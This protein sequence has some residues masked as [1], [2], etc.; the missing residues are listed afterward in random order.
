MSSSSARPWIWA[1]FSSSARSDGLM[2]HHWVRAKVEYPDYP[3]ARFDVHLDPVEYPPP[4]GTSTTD[5]TTTS[6]LRNAQSQLQSSLT[7]PR[8][9]DTSSSSSS[10]E[11]KRLFYKTHLQ[12]PNWTQTETDT[13]LHLCHIH[14]LRWPIIHDKWQSHVSHSYSS[15]NSNNSNH[16]HN[17][18]T[19]P[20]LQHRYYTIGQI[21]NRHLVQQ[22]AANEAATLARN[23]LTTTTSRVGNTSTSTTP[24][25]GGG[26]GGSSSSSGGGGGGVDGRSLA[27][28][29]TISSSSPLGSKAVST[30]LEG[31]AYSTN[32]STQP[33]IHHVGTG[34][35]NA[36]VFDLEGEL[37]RREQLDK[38][39]N[40]PKELELEEADLRQ[41][42]TWITSRIRKLKKSGRHLMAAR[43]TH[44]A[45]AAAG[46]SGGGVTPG[47]VRGSGGGGGGTNKTNNTVRGGSNKSPIPPSTSTDTTTP[48]EQVFGNAPIPTAGTPYLQS[49]RLAPPSTKSGSGISKATLKRMEAILA[50][51]NITSRPTV[52]TKR[53]C[54]LY[55]FVRRDALTLLT[56]QKICA[57]KEGEVVNKRVKLEKMA[58]GAVA[59]DLANQTLLAQQAAAAAAAAQAASEAASN[60]TVTKKG[61]KGG[62]GSKGKGGGKGAGKK[63]GKKKASG[64]SGGTKTAGTKRKAPAKKSASKG[65]SAAA[66]GGGGAGPAGPVVAKGSKSTNPTLVSGSASAAKSPSKMS[67]ASAAAAAAQKTI[68]SPGDGK[69]KKRAKK[70]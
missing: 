5:A 49:G 56:L 28:A 58:G 52:P 12:H 63:G 25:E 40:R 19:L 30:L 23:A 59:Q 13:L 69:P 43:R 36:K 16:N 64:E 50:E 37:K 42:L 38:V 9:D 18:K 24:T 62:G 7:S 57:K 35:S 27:L 4:T 41:E 8:C 44:A 67:S 3:Y 45:A 15:N 17:H 14:E 26:I 65:G 51:L 46:A 34:T 20:H 10:L 22:A 66:S 48:L 33:M 60:K 31:H 47:V 2:L 61:G 68:G 1:P 39:W 21:L 32:T 29:Q 11:A 6:S 55:D 53:I 70:N 54:D